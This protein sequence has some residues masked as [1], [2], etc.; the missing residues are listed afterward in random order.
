MRSSSCRNRTGGSGSKSE[1][2]GVVPRM[3]CV[4]AAGK[5]WPL[6]D[7]KT[8]SP[9]P[10]E[11]ERGGYRGEPNAVSEPHF[12]GAWVAPAQPSIAAWI[13]DALIPKPIPTSLA[14]N[15]FAHRPFVPADFASAQLPTHFKVFRASRVLCGQLTNSHYGRGRTWKKS[16]NRPPPPG[17]ALR[18]KDQPI[19]RPAQ[20]RKR[21]DGGRRA[22]KPSPLRR[23]CPGATRWK[24]SSRASVGSPRG[25][26]LAA[27]PAIPKSPSQPEGCSEIPASNLSL[28]LRFDRSRCLSWNRWFRRGSSGSG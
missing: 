25:W 20:T 1:E 2:A 26:H 6:S 10:R 27:P 13:S 15:P 28:F 12:R 3:R 18:C 4:V 16:A 19:R 17:C 11:R 22:V 7:V 24:P 5:F 23:G 9:P 21:A 8:K 14:P